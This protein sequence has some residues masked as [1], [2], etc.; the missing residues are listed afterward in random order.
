MYIP[1]TL[2]SGLVYI[3]SFNPYQLHDFELVP[4]P[5]KACILVLKMGAM[6]APISWGCWGMQWKVPVSEVARS[7]IRLGSPP[8]PIY[9]SPRCSRAVLTSCVLNAP[10]GTSG[11][12]QSL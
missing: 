11:L 10:P 9:S 2:L 7:G 4:W 12:F 5:L 1:D 3:V 6:I 8:K